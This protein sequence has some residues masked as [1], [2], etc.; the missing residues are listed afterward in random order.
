MR[1]IIPR[2]CSCYLENVSFLSRARACDNIQCLEV[3]NRKIQ[4]TNKAQIF[5]LKA[6]SMLDSFFKNWCGFFITENATVKLEAFLKVSIC[7]KEEFVQGNSRICDIQPRVHTGNPSD[8]FCSLLL[9]A[10]QRWAIRYHSGNH[11]HFQ[12]DSDKYS[13]FCLLPWKIKSS[14][15]MSTGGLLSTGDHL[16]GKAYMKRWPLTALQP[17]KAMKMLYSDINQGN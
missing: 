2:P 15:S 11:Y 10:L 7:F 1:W 8:T 9:P 17:P 3:K 5:K 13:E 4:I 14:M 6:L 12:L 16:N